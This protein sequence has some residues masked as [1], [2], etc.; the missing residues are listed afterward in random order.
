[1]SFY[2]IEL[3]IGTPRPQSVRLLVDTGS[4]ET[5]VNSPVSDFCEKGENDCG[6]YG[7]FDPNS[8]ASVVYI[9]MSQFKAFYSDNTGAKG[10]YMKDNIGFG[11]Q[12]LADFQFGLATTTFI[13]HGTLGLG[14]VEKEHQVV[15]N[16]G[17]GY[18][19]FPQALYDQKL[20][21]TRAYSLWLNN[22]DAQTG[23]IVFGGV[24]M[25]KFSGK[26]ST[27][28]SKIPAQFVLGLQRLSWG[29]ISSAPFDVMLDSGAQNAILPI[30]FVR[31]VWTKMNAIVGKSGSPYVDCN[32]ARDSS[33]MDFDFGT[34]KIS[35]PMTQIVYHNP[36]EETP[37]PAGDV[38]YCSLG[39][40]PVQKPDDLAVLGDV[41][42]RSAYVVYDLARS[43]I[44]IAQ[45]TTGGGESNIVDLDEGGV[46][47]LHM[48]LGASGSDDN[49]LRA[50]N[51]NAGRRRGS[52]L[53][54]GINQGS[55]EA[56]DDENDD[57]GSRFVNVLRDKNGEEVSFLKR[58]FPKGSEMSFVNR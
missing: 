46:P 43:E 7:T 37:P 2:S 45:A 54:N 40:V 13:R 16:Q 3:L 29:E 32:L 10:D 24:D 55:D 51:I 31:S 30:D 4:S 39:I 38:S 52:R 11:N 47:K 41:F 44:S 48:S 56:V 15:H 49:R 20:I 33:N 14:Y 57:Y 21:K 50:N 34:T 42:L 1:M 18:P 36:D 5:W 9:Q 35:V 27:F 6:A 25:A 22:M 53:R 8:S 17:P 19:N 23:S 12:V 28:P 58:P 26:L